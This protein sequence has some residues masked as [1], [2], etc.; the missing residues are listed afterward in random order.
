MRHFGG[1][2]SLLRPTPSCWF[3]QFTVVQRRQV[4]LHIKAVC[5]SLPPGFYRLPHPLEAAA[6]EVIRSLI[7]TAIY[8]MKTGSGGESE[9]SR[10]AAVELYERRS[11]TLRAIKAID[12]RSFSCVACLSSLLLA[13]M[14]CSWFRFKIFVVAGI[15]FFTD[16]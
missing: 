12:E 15:G 4:Y 1:A 9:C 13:Y 11:D 3:T 5:A 7:S 16:A 8:W 14:L 2:V 6:V 10:S